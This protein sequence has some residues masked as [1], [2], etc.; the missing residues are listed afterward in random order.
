MTDR[1][2][3]KGTAR[4]AYTARARPMQRLRTEHET[5]ELLSVSKRTVQRLINSGALPVHRFGRLVRIADDDIAA[6]LTATRSF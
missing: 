1:L 2:I 6:L 4:F 3:P 5:A